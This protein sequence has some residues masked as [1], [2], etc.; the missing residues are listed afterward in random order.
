MYKVTHSTLGRTPVSR[1]NVLGGLIGG[2]A[3]SAGPWKVALA[4]DTLIVNAYGGEFGDI[5]RQTVITPFEKKFGVSVTLDDTGTSSTNYAKIRATGGAPGFDVASELTAAENIL[6]GKEKLLL[7]VTEKEVPNLAHVWAKSRTQVAGNG[8]VNYY[9][10]AS[11]F[12]NKD[13]IKAPDS[14][15][16]YFHAT[17]KYGPDIKGRLLAF[18]PANVLEVYALALGAEAHGGGLTNMDPGW[19]LLQDQKPLLSQVPTMSSAA[20]PYF[21]NGSVWMAPFWSSRAAY[22]KSR[23]LPF[24]F[25]IPKEG[26]MGLGGTSGIP[27]NASNPKLAY[28]F[29]NFR[30][31]PEIQRAFCLAYFASP[32]RADTTDWPADFAEKQIVTQAKMDA[33]QLPD[34]IVI[35]ANIRAW[36]LKFQEIMAG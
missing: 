29:L 20:V 12:Y 2:L 35:G 27:I 14:W 6:G 10:Y 15:L 32:G 24:D 4:A 22:Y 26:T 28:E 33:L 23:G 19:K 3:A 25:V 11:L 30:L 7:P 17:A 8:T 34:P 1:R 21:E 9:H 5:L 36:T 18:D 13:K 16:D 31:E